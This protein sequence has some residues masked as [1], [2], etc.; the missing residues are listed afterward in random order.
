[1]DPRAVR[2]GAPAF[3]DWR[4]DAPGV[5]RRITTAD[6]PPPNA[7]AS[8]HNGPRIVRRPASAAPQVPQG[9]RVD[10]FASDLDGPRALKVAPNGD[11]F[12]AETDAGRVRVLRATD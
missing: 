7:T 9:F 12:V 8:A 3:G 5:R 1:M 4:A 6:L 11:I 2:T 10:L